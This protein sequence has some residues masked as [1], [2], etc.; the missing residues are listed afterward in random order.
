MDMM[1]LD[2]RQ[3]FIIFVLCSAF[4][5]FMLAAFSRVIICSDALH[6]YKR[7]ANFIKFVPLPDFR[8]GFCGFAW[9]LSLTD[10][11]S[12]ADRCIDMRLAR[13][14]LPNFYVHG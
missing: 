5:N 3:I 8:A 2:S 4:K 12:N 11:G 1:L 6:E 7:V 10:T 13:M 14:N 9:R